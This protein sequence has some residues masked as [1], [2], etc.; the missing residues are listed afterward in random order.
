MP[1]EIEVP[2]E[3]SQEHIE[4][5]HEEHEGHHGEGEEKG[6]SG[7]TRF[8]A[9]ATAILAVVAAIG[10]LKSGLLVNEALLAKND[11]LLQKS[12]QVKHLT[13]KSDSYNYYQ[14][15]G[16]KALIYQTAAQALPPGSPVAQEDRKQSGHYKDKQDEIKKQADESDTK[17]REAEEKA[18]K[19][20]EES[21]Q[22]MEKHH[23]FAFSVSLCQIA[24]ALSAIAA[25]TRSRRVW[26]FGLA[27]GLAG[28]A[29][30]VGGFL[31]LH[32]PFAF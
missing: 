20:N 12:E 31:G 26:F 9:V 1:D 7:W 11:A 29:A 25:L 4:K 22:I 30:L 5:A 21:A 27:A 18:A 24:I 8:I 32:L 23:M 28:I 6:K 13:N 14:A 17:S 15:E 19:D 3:Q 2:L 16:L 10:A